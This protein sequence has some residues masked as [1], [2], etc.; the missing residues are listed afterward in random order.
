M[1]NL[2]A[3]HYGGEGDVAEAIAASLR[4]AGKDMTRL[5]TADLASVDEFHIGGRAATLEL[6][7]H[8]KL[9]PS[10]RVLDIGSGLGGPARTL[11][12]T[13]SCHVTGVD[14]TPAFC[15]AAST[16][17]AWV[18]LSEHIGFQQGDATALPFG[19]STFDAAMTIHVA[20]NI[21]AKDRMYQ[22]ARRVLRRGA[23]FGVYDVL[24]G[25]GGDVLYPVPWARQ[26]SISH[27]VTPT[28]MSDLLSRAGFSIAETRDSTEES[29]RWFETLAARTAKSAPP[30]TFRL[31]LGDAFPEMAMNQ[32]Q[33]LKERRIRTVSYICK[34]P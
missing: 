2:V 22:E 3:R 10:S 17:S 8:L 13:Y 14:L 16:L 18:G 34:V 33:N 30:V 4:N 9:G 26:P 19:D 20:M 27:L 23:H 6:A 31:F 11:A 29:Q 24:Q 25:E 32:V 5:T 1:D 12:E 28:E 15:S 7:R 21:A